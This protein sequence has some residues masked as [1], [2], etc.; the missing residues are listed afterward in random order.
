MVKSYAGFC[1][2][3]KMGKYVMG[4]GILA[5]GGVVL[6]A[7]KGKNKEVLQKELRCLLGSNPSAI[8]RVLK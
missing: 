2:Y 1:F 8:G 4:V 6:L 7:T 3:E 5:I